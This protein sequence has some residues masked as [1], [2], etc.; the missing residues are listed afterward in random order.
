MDDQLEENESL[1]VKNRLNL[2]KSE[3]YNGLNFDYYNVE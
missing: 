2:R 3:K 1:K